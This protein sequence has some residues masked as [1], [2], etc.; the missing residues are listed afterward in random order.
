MRRPRCTLRAPSACTGTCGTSSAPR[1]PAWTRPTG[2]PPPDGDF[3]HDFLYL[4]FLQLHVGDH[5]LQ[6]LAQRT[7]R[8]FKLLLELEHGLVGVRNQ[9]P[10]NVDR[11]LQLA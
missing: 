10:L 11:D 4:I 1:I 6:P 3:T 9:R 7:E 2:P 8:P 5:V